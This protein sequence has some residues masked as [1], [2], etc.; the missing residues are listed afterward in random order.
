MT[1][2]RTVAHQNALSQVFKR[3]E[4]TLGVIIIVLFVLPSLLLVTEKVVDKT[5]FSKLFRRKQKTAVE[6]VTLSPDFTEPSDNA[7]K[8]QKTENEQG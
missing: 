1:A 4:F 2:N 8:A 7:V 6:E 5:D 3:T